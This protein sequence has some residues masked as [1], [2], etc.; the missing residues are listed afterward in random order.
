[1]ERA[2]GEFKAKWEKR[3][4]K[5]GVLTV[6]GECSLGAVYRVDLKPHDP[7]SEDPDLLLLDLVITLP[8]GL[9]ATKVEGRA[10]LNFSHKEMIE[11]PPT[12]VRIVDVNS[13]EDPKDQWEIPVRVLTQG[14]AEVRPEGTKWSKMSRPDRV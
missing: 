12:R 2:C 3:P 9:P 1:M 10:T 11:D 13:E 6:A 14:L 8:S 4:D 7:P 5:A